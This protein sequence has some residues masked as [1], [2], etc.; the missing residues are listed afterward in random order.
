MRKFVKLTQLQQVLNI[1]PETEMMQICRNRFGKIREIKVGELLLGGF[2]SLKTLCT[3][4]QYTFAM[5][6]L[7]KE[8]SVQCRFTPNQIFGK[9]LQSTGKSQCKEFLKLD[10]P[11]SLLNWD[12]S[13][14]AK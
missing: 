14:M 6:Y 11:T 5:Q 10:L 1:I 12:H 2:Q 8:I 4:Q 7:S 9:G 3:S 13:S